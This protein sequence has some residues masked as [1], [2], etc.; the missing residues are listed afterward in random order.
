MPNRQK[1]RPPNEESFPT[2]RAPPPPRPWVPPP[3]PHSQP[4]ADWVTHTLSKL[5]HGYHET[6]QEVRAQNVE[7]ERRRIIMEA[8]WKGTRTFFRPLQKHGW[9][10]MIGALYLLITY[11]VTGSVPN[12]IELIKAIK[13]G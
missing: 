6:V 10:V 5:E 1:R 7:L 11:L 9:L 4:W 8:R 3:P 2:S 13:G 12:A